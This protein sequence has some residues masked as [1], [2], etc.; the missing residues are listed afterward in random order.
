M[1][2]ALMEQGRGA[3]DSLGVRALLRGPRGLGL[4]A[5][6]LGAAYPLERWA[7]LARNL[8]IYDVMGAMWAEAPRRATWLG[9]LQEGVGPGKR[10]RG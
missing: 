3:L 1:Q 8:R 9:R 6:S 4:G 2:T 10:G 7:L 5:M